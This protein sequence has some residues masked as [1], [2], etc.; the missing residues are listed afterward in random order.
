M[1]LLIILNQNKAMGKVS[2]DSDLDKIRK[3]N[4]NTVKLKTEYNK[5]ESTKTVKIAVSS[6]ITFFA[7]WI[8]IVVLGNA[9]SKDMAPKEIAKI[10]NEVALDAE[11]QFYMAKRQGDKMQTY[12]QAGLVSAAYLQANDELNYDKWKVIQ[13][14]CERSVH[15]Y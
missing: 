12:V 11:R 13:D 6:I 1:E 9:A 7:I 2:N 4:L 5:K 3:K 15:L 8:L 14:S 10:K